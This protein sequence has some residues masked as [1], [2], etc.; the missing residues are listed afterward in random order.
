MSLTLSDALSHYRSVSD[1]TH[2]FWG[3]FQ[4]VAVG[5]AAFAW[6]SKVPVEAQL[7]G[8]LSIAF[9]IFAALNWRLVVS[10]QAEAVIAAECL[11][12]YA[13]SLGDTVPSDLLPIIDR[14]NPYSPQR[15]GLWHV[16]L[17]LA[18]L[19]QSGGGT[20]R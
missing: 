16:V 11:K 18:A 17:S 8:F 9:A 15:I 14:I 3:Y 5:T 7:F 12:K 1:A 20:T 10:S 19:E 4:A 6:S 2:K 13:A